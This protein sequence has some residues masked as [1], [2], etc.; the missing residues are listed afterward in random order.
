MRE[1]MLAIMIL[2]GLC[3]TQTEA[4]EADITVG[5][6]AATI[7]QKP[8]ISMT[9]IPP[10]PVTDKIELDIRGAV[11]NTSGAAMK[12]DVAFYLDDEKAGKPLYRASLDVA[13]HA[14]EGLKFRWPTSQNAGKHRL[15]MIAKAGGKELRSEQPIEILASDIRSNR[16][17]GGAWVDIYHHNLKEGVPFNDELAKM[18]EQNWRE[19]V[20]AMHNTEQ[21]ILV[22]SMT[23]QNIIPRKQHKI[24]TEGYPGKAYY[25]SKLFPGRMPIATHDPLEVIFDEADK[26]GMHVMPGVGCYAWH[27]YSRGSLEWHK[28]VARE[29]W[30]LYGHHPS[31]YGWYICEEAKGSLGD[32]EERK[33]I[34]EYFKEFTPFA[35]G[36]APDRPVMLAPNCFW[37]SGAEETYKQLLPNLD[38]ICPFGFHRM[39]GSLTGEQT[40]VLL[41]SL[42][43][44]AGCHLWMDLESFVFRNGVELYP[45]PIDGFVSD[46]TRF[47]NFEKTLHYQFPGLMSSPEMTRKPGGAA[48]VELYEDYRRYLRRCALTPSAPS[49]II[50]PIRGTWINLFH[51][52]IRNKFT[53]REGVDMTSPELWRMKIKEMHD[54]GVEYLVFY[55]VA[56]EGKAMYESGFLAH[57]YPSGQESPVSVIMKAADDH[58]MKVFMSCGWARDAASDGSHP[59]AFETQS[60]I[61]HEVAAQF[62]KHP[63]F[64]GWYFPSEFPIAPTISDAFIDSVN[65][66]SA[67]ARKLTPNAKIMTSPYHPFKAKVDDRYVSQLSKMDVDIIAYQ[68]GV[69]SATDIRKKMGGAH[70]LAGNGNT[71]ADLRWAH[72]QVPRIALWANAETFTWESTPFKHWLPLV[73]AAFPRI[74]S[75]MASASPHVDETIS[76]IV[77]GMFEK[78]ASPMPTGQ[79]VWSEKL[80]QDY[81]DYRAGKGRWPFLGASLTG[82]LTNEALGKP[83]TLTTP[84]DPK[85]KTGHLTDGKFGV[86]T[87]KDP[88]WLGFQNVDLKATIDLGESKAITSLAGRFLQHKPSGIQLPSRVEF[89]VSEDGKA[90]RNV[91][92]VTLERWGNDGYDCWI[93]MA[94]TGDLKEQGRYV[95]V[96]AVNAGQWL[97]VDELLVNPGK[98]K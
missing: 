21:D 49:T 42:C 64:Y 32:A 12:F 66:R 65:K 73:P 16:R 43:D 53:Y 2:S 38:I 23:F 9:L 44:E 93:D 77:Q 75:Q 97:F 91:A 57:A 84:A 71:F 78:P 7:K 95:R 52:D 15:V 63:S 48:T 33:E 27:D 29:I 92:E 96:H 54:M 17:L 88:P 85:Y 19:L 67:E 72:K 20:R 94:V 51:E 6:A 25:P 87:I 62:G 18:T 4:M 90:F 83:V 40:A 31:F 30:D 36:L 35:H 68:D 98:T 50:K 5:S 13:A 26:L 22:I 58:K 82:N 89:S 8:E 39:R 3:L 28:K 59:E 1:R 74:L 70:L 69:G 61:M 47:P 34:V 45:R 37:V 80:A 11:R 41:Q 76:W 14:V 24:E 10:S 60:K 86:E 56:F 55:S 81:M 79:P 46:F